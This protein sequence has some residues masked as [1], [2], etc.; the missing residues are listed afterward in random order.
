MLG[1]RCNHDCDILLPSPTFHILSACAK[2][3][4]NPLGF[5]SLCPECG[6]TDSAAVN[7]RLVR[8][9]VYLDDF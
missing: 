4:G 1:V 3:C 2:V 9:V 6:V 8:E 5:G 7:R